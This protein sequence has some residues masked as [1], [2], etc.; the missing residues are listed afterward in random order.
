MVIIALLITLNSCCKV[1]RFDKD[2]TF[3][4]DVYNVG[5]TLIF[6]SNKPLENGKLANTDTIFILKKTI[7]TPTGDC[8]FMVTNI[9]AEGC[10]IDYC[11]T[12]NSVKS[13]PIMLVQHF[14]EEEGS[15]YPVLRVF[16]NEYSGNKLKDTSIVLNTIGV[17]LKDCYTFHGSSEGWG[18]KLKTYVWSKKLGLVMYTGFNGEKFE[19]QKKIGNEQKYW[20]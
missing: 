14:K 8:N 4:T 16:W 11:Y 20:R 2:E 10:V 12:H 7:Y 3:W 18:D 5:D 1:L 17:K 15:S 9:D 13:E 6:K 19:F